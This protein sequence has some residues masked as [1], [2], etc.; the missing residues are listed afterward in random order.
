[1]KGSP[2]DHLCPRRRKKVSLVFDGFH[3]QLLATSGTIVLKSS[4]KRT[5]F[6]CRQLSIPD[7]PLSGALD[8]PRMVPP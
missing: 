1:M 7:V 6:A 3:S 8:R 4:E 2:S 5:K